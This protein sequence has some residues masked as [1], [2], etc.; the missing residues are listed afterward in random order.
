MNGLLEGK[1]GWTN[2]YRS[3]NNIPIDE[4]RGGVM[5]ERSTSAVGAPH[6][7]PSQDQ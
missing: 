6:L 4:R 7:L 3:V 1:E 5:F 2:N